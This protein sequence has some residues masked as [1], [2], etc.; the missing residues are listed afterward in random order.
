[1]KYL[2]KVQ[3]LIDQFA[4]L[5]AELGWI[6]LGQALGFVGGFLGIKVLTNF[7]GPNGYGQLAL[8][9]SIAGVLS[10]YVYGPVANVVARYFVV[11]RER[12][13]LEVYFS[14]LKKWHRQLLILLSLVAIVVTGIAV[15]WVGLEWALLVLFS[16]LYGIS[17]GINSSYLAM[18]S[19]IRQRKIVALHQGLDVWLRVG[20][21]VALL[22][23]FRNSG[24]VV[25]L[26]YLCGTLLITVSQHC[27][28]MKND[29]I[30]QHWYSENI[31]KESLYNGRCEF[32]AY[33]TPFIFFAGFAI[34]SLYADRWI[35]QVVGGASMVGVYAAIFQIASSPVNLLFSLVN[36]LMVP[37]VF[38]RAGAMSSQVQVRESAD[39]LRQT[40][41]ASASA[42]FLIIIVAIFFSN[43][44]MRL[45]TNQLFAANHNILWIIILGLVLYNIGQLFCLK[46]M[47][48]NQPNIY[49]WPKGVQAL[50]LLLF[51]YL[52][53]WHD[54]LVGMAWALCFSSVLYV[55]AVLIVN[56][57]LRLKFDCGLHTIA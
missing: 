54:G 33:A 57:K 10:T 32:L 20:I 1:M 24:Y 44:I 5:K 7:M 41:L 6:M 30:R 52:F 14:V 50:S 47:Y 9:L 48:S 13:T 56:Y 16:A 25:L 31:K 3:Q 34:V 15:L 22:L 11:Y 45:F 35:I 51:G 53:T 37:I 49:F 18:Q 17:S 36:Q 21:S 39:L 8:G 28:A 42:S 46:G 2:E 43:P 38:E 29:E 4:N 27:F 12:R 55:V 40:V 23:L 19:A 26:G